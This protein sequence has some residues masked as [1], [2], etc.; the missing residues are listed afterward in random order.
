MSDATFD[1][2]RRALLGGMAAGLLPA[3]LDAAV[4]ATPR[5][6]GSI[7][8]ASVASSTADTLDPAK[9]GLSTDYVRHYMLYSGLTQFDGKLR[10]RMAL[11][12][13]IET[14]DNID[15]H[16]RLRRGVTFHNGKTLTARDVVHSL[17]RHKDPAIGSKVAT[18]AEQIEGARAAGPL[19]VHVRLTGPNPELPAILAQSHFLIVDAD[20][21]S[22]ATANG[23]GPYT[24][25]AFQP[26]IRTIVQR[27]QNY[28]KP[29][30]PY[31]DRI[32]LIAIPDEISRVNALLSGDV[33]AVIGVSPGSVKR[34]RASGG[35]DVVETPSGL[36][37]DLVMRRD[38][39][40]TA[41]ADFVLA[42]KY[43][44]DRELIKRALFRGFATI[45]N[46]QPL[47]PFHPMYNPN[48]PQRPFDPE[49]A[50]FHLRRAGL[51]GARMPV[52]VSP[53]ANQ[54]VDMGSILQEHAAQVGLNLAINRVPSDGYWS[55][56]WMKHPLTFGNINPRPT[57][58]LTFSQAF[59]S[60]SPWN[61]AGWKSA[62]FDR[63]LAEA[64]ATTDP[65]R[66][67]MLYGDMQYL[68]NRHGS[69]VIPVFM[70]VLDGIDRRL[71]G[72]R[73]IPL[74]GLM[75]YTFAEYVWWDA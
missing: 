51:I 23:T 1:L 62:P 70:S 20:A 66:R 72:M 14:R 11:A 65:A 37:T 50:R 21:R 31:L 58:D 38:N 27:N 13:R 41:G 52:Y 7:R 48:V 45:A 61:E 67:K 26:G 9:G 5:R 44:F 22:F 57:A 73:P 29:G 53:A 69:V 74:G 35:H 63:L 2:S 42:M 10:A 54:S 55:T 28:W 8:V 43:L 75:G 3:G 64:R 46:D 60:S 49:R 18:I 15:W 68:I 4:P 34:V 40:V 39:P 25:S 16:I 32:E 12:E 6:G 59:S 71:K 33:H 30:R 24:L 17:L 47:P 36:Y 56:H 19:D